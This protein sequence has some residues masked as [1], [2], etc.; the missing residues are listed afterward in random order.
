MQYHINKIGH[1]LIAYKVLVAGNKLDFRQFLYNVLS[2][3]KEFE[4]IG[5]ANNANQACEMAKQNKTDLLILDMDINRDLE[6]LK[7]FNVDCPDLK[8]ILTSYYDF[9]EYAELAK[10]LN[11]A[12]FIPKT[13]LSTQSILDILRMKK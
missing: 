3:N 8:V 4:V 2:S 9:N 12:A 7:T 1:N 11:A 6:K 5:E 13:R 10:K